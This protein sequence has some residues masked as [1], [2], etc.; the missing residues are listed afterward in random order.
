[1]FLFPLLLFVPSFFLPSLLSLLFLPFSLPPFPFLSSSSLFSLFSFLL[2]S[3]P[4]PL[5]PFSPSSLFF[6]FFFLFP[7]LFSF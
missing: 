7:L 2:P 1:F 6:P 3:L 4:P 5:L